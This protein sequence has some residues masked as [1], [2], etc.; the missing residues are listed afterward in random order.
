MVFLINYKLMQKEADANYT[1]QM[2]EEGGRYEVISKD[3]VPEIAC[4]RGHHQIFVVGEIEKDYLPN[5]T[6]HPGQQR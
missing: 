4:E 1:S 5:F 6:R 3:V 2:G